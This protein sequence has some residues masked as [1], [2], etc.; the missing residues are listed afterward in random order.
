[1]TKISQNNKIL[2]K[3]I[4]VGIEGLSPQEALSEF[5]CFRLAARIK[6]LKNAG[7]NIENKGREYGKQYAIYVLI[8]SK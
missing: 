5:G 1:M 3:L 8:D 7:H 4:D 2:K 6:D